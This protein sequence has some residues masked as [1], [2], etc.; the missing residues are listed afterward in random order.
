M[1]EPM[2]TKRNDRNKKWAAIIVWGI[3][4]TVAHGQITAVSPDSAAQGT[5]GLKV[6]MTLNSNGMPPIPPTEALVTSVKI[7]TVSGTSVNRISQFIVKA[8]F[9]I[10]AGA[11]SGAKDVSITFSGPPT[12]GEGLTFSMTGGFTLTTMPNTAPSITTQPKSQAVRLGNSAILTVGAYGSAPLIY[13]WQKGEIDIIAANSASYTI[14]AFVEGE[15]GERY[16]N[17]VRCV[18]NLS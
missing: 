17:Y 3:L 2:K 7:G 18:R 9:D 8:V 13:Q 4:L 6:T 1:N 10:P 5:A 12:G 15:G 14:E 16:Y 11:A